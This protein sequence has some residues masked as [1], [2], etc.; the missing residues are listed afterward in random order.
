MLLEVGR[1]LPG[2]LLGLHAIKEVSARDSSDEKYGLLT[3][4]KLGMSL[5]ALLLFRLAFLLSVSVIVPVIFSLRNNSLSKLYQNI[6]RSHLIFLVFF[7]DMFMTEMTPVTSSSSEMMNPLPTSDEK[8][9][10]VFLPGSDDL[11]VL[12]ELTE[13]ALLR[14]LLP[15]KGLSARARLSRALL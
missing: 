1:E 7:L 12:T 9:M 6:E 15:E 14:A 4:R 8:Y 2:E 3:N 10:K 11:P 13:L 5:A